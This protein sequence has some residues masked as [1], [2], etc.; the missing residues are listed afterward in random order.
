MEKWRG[1]DLMPPP[2]RLGRPGRDHPS[3]SNNQKNGKTPEH[4][5]SPRPL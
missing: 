3:D 1:I 5:L 2:P 4:P